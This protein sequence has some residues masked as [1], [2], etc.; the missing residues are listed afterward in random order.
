[1]QLH[2]GMQDL[3]VEL[4]PVGTE[5]EHEGCM[6]S[7]PVTA[8]WLHCPCPSPDSTHSW[9][10][11]AATPCLICTNQPL[12]S[13]SHELNIP[14]T[15]GTP[16]QLPC[17][18]RAA[19][20]HLSGGRSPEHPRK[21]KPSAPLAQVVTNGCLVEALSLVQELS[22]VLARVLQQ[23]VLDQELDALQR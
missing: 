23:V 22:D 20:S 2:K 21:A 19:V 12:A 18:L 7:N 16:S 4:I 14:S 5:P 8:E 17:E 11:A 9:G 15:P 1:M 6:I 3:D 10:K 13:A